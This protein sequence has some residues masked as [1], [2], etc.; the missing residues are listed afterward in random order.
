MKNSILDKTESMFF[1]VTPIENLELICIVSYEI[2]EEQYVEENI[3]TL[4]IGNMQIE[5]P[6]KL[7]EERARILHINSQKENLE[8]IKRLSD[9]FY[10]CLKPE[11]IISSIQ[12]QSELIDYLNGCID[13]FR[14]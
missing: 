6:E 13:V 10:K 3:M 5:I 4:E 1:H 11:E 9:I 7:I 8:D 12:F 2:M 14:P